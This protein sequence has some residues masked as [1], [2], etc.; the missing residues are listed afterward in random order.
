MLEIN[1]LRV[2]FRN[3][4]AVV[5]V[6]HG[7]SLDIRPGEIVGLVGESGS[8]KST[9]PLAML[10]LLP[11]NA[12]IGGQA[13]FENRTLDIANPA[14][15]R[16]IL[17]GRASLIFQQPLKAFSPYATFG[18]QLVDAISAQTGMSRTDAGKVALAALEDVQMPDPEGA[19][20]RYPHQVSGGQ[21][22]RV[23]IALALSCNP[24]LL[25]ADE[26]TTALDVTVQAQVL[27]LIR[28]LAKSRGIGVLFITHDLG[29]V[30][31]LCDRVVV[32][33][34][35]RVCET[36][37][38]AGLF[39]H[40]QHRY[41]RALLGSMP[42]LGS[43][44]AFE[45]IP[46]SAPSPAALPSGCA[47]HPRCAAATERCRTELPQM[48]TTEAGRFACWNPVGSDKGRVV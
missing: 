30:A 34:A 48:V 4:R 36:A 32:L 46:G 25:V 44:Q 9:T 21:A 29:V 39:H 40:P 18:R 5:Q 8:G 15:T 28:E 7:V 17:G 27:H 11:A 3:R 20:A 35:G 38:V 41:T 26:P 45:T 13:R 6:L 22:Q 14:A 43:A 31:E 1:D 19:M 33:Y 12:V 10:G 42:H 16:K 2:G 37:P 47:F 23:M 24:K